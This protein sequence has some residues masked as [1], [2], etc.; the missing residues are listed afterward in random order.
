VRLC[1]DIAEKIT[2]RKIRTTKLNA[3]VLKGDIR[4]NN[5]LNRSYIHHDE[6]PFVDRHGDSC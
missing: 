1:S 6:R 3:H 5:L 4:A 2:F